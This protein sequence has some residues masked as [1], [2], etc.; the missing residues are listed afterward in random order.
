MSII[1]DPTLVMLSV[2]VAIIGS[3]TGLAFTFGLCGA[4]TWDL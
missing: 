3:L 1:Y 2:F 4:G